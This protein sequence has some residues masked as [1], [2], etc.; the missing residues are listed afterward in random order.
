MG[1]PI[2]GGWRACGGAWLAVC[3]GDGF[4]GVHGGSIPRI[5]VALSATT[6]GGGLRAPAELARSQCDDQR[7]DDGLKAG[8]AA[9]AAE[10]FMLRMLATAAWT[11]KVRDLLR[12]RLSTD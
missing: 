11:D 5:V 2:G 6:R 3:G 10:L 4:G 9:K 7:A 1:Q 8:C 12:L